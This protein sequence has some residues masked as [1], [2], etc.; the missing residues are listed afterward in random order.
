MIDDLFGL[1]FSFIKSFIKDFIFDVVCFS[2]G[3]ALL[4]VITLG[5]YPKIS[6]VSG[7]TDEESQDNLSVLIG[8]I[9]LSYLLYNGYLLWFG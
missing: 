9:I 8:G 5:N 7:I 1:L 4:R 3:W 6:L 2:L